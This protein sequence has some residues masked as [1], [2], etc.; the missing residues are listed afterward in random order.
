MKLY[1]YMGKEL[2]ALQQ[3]P[4]PRG[5]VVETPEEAEAV[6]KELGPVVVKSQVLTGKRGKAGA[7]AFADT[8]EEAGREATRLLQ[9]EVGGEKVTRLLLEEQLPPDKELYLSLVVEGETRC[10]VVLASMHGGVDIEEVPEEH[11][12]KHTIDPLLGYHPY[13]AREICHQLGLEGKAVKSFIALLGKLY[14]LF[15]EKDAE[16]LEINPLGLRGEDL[17]A[18]DAK[19]VIDDDALYRQK[20]LPV[21]EEKTALEKKAS[22]IGLA[23]V[24]LGGDIAVMAN[25]AGITMATLDL[26]QHFGGTPA[27]FLDFG[28]G[29]S[30]ETAYSALELLLGTEPRV[31]LINIFGGITRCDVVARAFVN[32][33]QSRGITIPFF[34]RLVGTKEEEGRQ[35]LQEAGVEVFS[36]MEEAVRQAVAASQNQQGRRT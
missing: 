8:P 28:G 35:I 16:L 24:D 18:L 17:L 20:E 13:I 27:N 11:I 10:P 4:V 15:Q 21:V 30:E 32:V 19:V 23:Y 14:Q 29:A 9:M 25:G 2:F 12:V 5:R 34:F 33:M 26:V 36:S 1:E 7:I 3:I 31:I 22:E 6:A